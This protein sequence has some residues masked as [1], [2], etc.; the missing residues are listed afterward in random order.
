MDADRRE[1]AA[2]TSR[3]GRPGGA[4]RTPGR[5][6]RLLDG[7]RSVAAL[8]ARTRRLGRRG[9]AEAREILR[10]AREAHGAPADQPLAS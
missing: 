4:P 3:A 5:Q 10:R 8:D 7:P 6:L 1:H 9:V 2:R